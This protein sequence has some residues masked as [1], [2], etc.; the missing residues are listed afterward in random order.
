MPEN[1]PRVSVVL[2][3]Y[4]QAEYLPKALASI[5]G[6]TFLDFDLIVV[7]DGSTDETEE[8]LAAFQ[9]ERPF[10][11]VRQTNQ[12]LPRALN[13]G[14]KIA[15]GRYLTWTSSDNVMLPRMLETLVVALDT[16]PNVGLVY[17]DWETIDENDRVLGTV[18]TLDYDRWVLMRVN[19]INACFMYRRE[20]QETVGLYDP[21]CI[22]AEDWEYWC[23]IARQF[24]MRRVPE[25]LYQYRVHSKSLTATVVKSPT[26]AGRTR[27]YPLGAGLRRRWLP[28]A[29]SK[30]RWEILRLQLGCDPRDY[31]FAGR[32]YL[33]VE[34]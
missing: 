26:N 18:R 20:C 8:V 23:R 33:S 2:P 24:P 7:N 13:A 3:T 30:L 5:L 6:Q 34:G 12:K 29:Y 22:Y 1:Q 21:N 10:T 31:L 25:V 16:Y 4:N 14:F 17:A 15:R 32:Q 28:W 27:Y 11:V 19:Y 9:R